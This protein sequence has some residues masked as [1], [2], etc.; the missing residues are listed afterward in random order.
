MKTPQRCQVCQKWYQHIEKHMREACGATIE[1]KSCTVCT[2][3]FSSTAQL[4]KHLGTKT[5]EHRTR[6]DGLFREPASNA[7][8]DGSSNGSPAQASNHLHRVGS[9]APAQANSNLSAEPVLSGEPVPTP[10]PAACLPQLRGAPQSPVVHPNIQ[11]TLQ[12]AL[13]QQQ[14]PVVRGD[15]DDNSDPTVY[16]GPG[17]QSIF[18][19]QLLDFTGMT[20]TEQ[21]RAFELFLSGGMAQEAASYMGN[22]RPQG[23]HSY[24]LA[25]RACLAI[26]LSS[27]EDSAPAATVARLQSQPH[28]YVPT[29]TKGDGVGGAPPMH[30]LFPDFTY[31]VHPVRLSLLFHHTRFLEPSCSLS[32]RCQSIIKAIGF[33][34]HLYAP[35]PGS[36]FHAQTRDAL[37]KLS[38]ARATGGRFQR[39]RLLAT[40]IVKANR[41]P[42]IGDIAKF[43]TELI[44]SMTES[45][46]ECVRASKRANNVTGLV[47][48][49]IT[50]VMKLAL[51]CEI[52]LQRP[53][54]VDHCYILDTPNNNDGSKGEVEAIHCLI[55]RISQGREHLVA[56]MVKLNDRWGIRVLQRKCAVTRRAEVTM[57]FF[58]FSPDML[59]LVTAYKK[60][61]ALVVRTD[62]KRV[63]ERR[64][65][66]AVATP[67]L[68]TARGVLANTATVSE[69]YFRLSIIA[70]QLG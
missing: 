39:N 6:R 44:A 32:L 30:R 9:A 8:A 27:L 1:Q 56:E 31:L 55:R 68:Q 52:P 66:V 5:H 42:L 36:V 28:Y 16:A 59:S 2:K 12:R 26:E 19:N 35:A 62:P 40:E 10:I 46:D 63:I 34:R 4:R 3:T 64:E 50:A 70:S 49:R 54:V 38:R 67:L 48:N 53:S 69:M 41:P 15:G 43:A 21:E 23:A 14:Q 20:A 45:L 58:P 24:A 60:L 37:D 25:V 33:L 29:T 17:K 61:S 65:G 13:H 11:V 51:W 57:P 47:F 22:Q 7:A 18:S